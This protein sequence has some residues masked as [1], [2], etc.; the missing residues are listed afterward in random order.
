MDGEFH[1]Y[2][3]EY[4]IL[5]FSFFLFLFFAV[6]V[7]CSCQWIFFWFR[8]NWKLPRC[9]ARMMH[10]IQQPDSVW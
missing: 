4:F 9:T 3:P 7:E 10:H 1:Q 5:Y 8:L 6:Y 2:S